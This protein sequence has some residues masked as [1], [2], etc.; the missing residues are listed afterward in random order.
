MKHAATRDFGSR[1]IEFIKVI[2]EVREGLLEVAGVDKSQWTTCLMQGSGTFG[3]ES[4]IAGR[5]SARSC[6]PRTVF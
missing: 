5:E 4:T 2:R 1:D 6:P 3:V